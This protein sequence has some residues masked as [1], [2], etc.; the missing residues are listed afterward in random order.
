[1]HIDNVNFALSIKWKNCVAWLNSI[2]SVFHWYGIT[3]PRLTLSPR[4][5]I[6]W[7]AWSTTRSNIFICW[8]FFKTYFHDYFTY[9][10]TPFIDILLYFFIAF[11]II[12]FCTFYGLAADRQEYCFT[13]DFFFIFFFSFF[14]LKFIFEPKNLFFPDPHS[15]FMGGP[16]PYFFKIFVSFRVKK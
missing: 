11:I 10:F 5:V 2:K 15:K 6:W 1:L 9:I 13:K 4:I 12:V 16:S 8:E 14:F 3:S 7:I